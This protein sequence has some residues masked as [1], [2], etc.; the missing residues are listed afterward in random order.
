LW[1]VAGIGN[2]DEEQNSERIREMGYSDG[3]NMDR[4]GWKEIERRLPKD[5]MWRMQWAIRKNKKGRAMG[6]IW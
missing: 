4:K 2:K 5:F 3:R 6:E 1:N